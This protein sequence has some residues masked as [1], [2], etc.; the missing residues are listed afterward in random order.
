MA[1]EQT[2]PQTDA[3][4]GTAANTGQSV[5]LNA[6]TEAVAGAETTAE[7]PVQAE[8]LGMPDDEQAKSFRQKERAKTS[9]ALSDALNTAQ[10]KT[11][12]TAILTAVVVAMMLFFAITP[13]LS[14][15]NTQLEK[16]DALRRR[17]QQLE[18][19]YNSLL[20]LQS[21]ETSMAQQLLEFDEILGESKQQADIYVELEA[22]TRNSRLTFRSLR[23]DEI[24]GTVRK[25][26]KLSL[27]ARIR[28]QRVKLIAQGD[29]N[30]GL[31]LLDA[32]EKSKRIF[33]IEDVSI[34]TPQSDDET[35]VQFDI[36]MRVLYWAAES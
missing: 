20:Q 27:S 26:E 12:S 24:T 8:D 25:Y 6:G 28:Y 32:I 30:N 4:E 16:N 22:L 18:T 2:T 15:I 9:N 23:F 36:T 34:I 35:G 1:E 21:K 5:D 10:G 17:N 19:K 33:D 14:S 3:A 13:A 11:F 31:N 29:I 7:Q